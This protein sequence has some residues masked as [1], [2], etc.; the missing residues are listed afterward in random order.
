[1]QIIPQMKLCGV[2]LNFVV[3]Y[4]YLGCFYL[5]LGGLVWVPF[6]LI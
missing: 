1:M 6:S 2:Y 5:T 3:F 4:F